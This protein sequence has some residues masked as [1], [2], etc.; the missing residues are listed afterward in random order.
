MSITTTM[1]TITTIITFTSP[2]FSLWLDNLAYLQPH[3]SPS[4]Q[5]TRTAVSPFSQRRDAADCAALQELC[6][7]HKGFLSTE[8]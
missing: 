4:G 2:E 7:E 5:Q 6:R 8:Y 3:K 1:N